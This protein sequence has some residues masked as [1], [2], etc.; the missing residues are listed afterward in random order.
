MCTRVELISLKF[1]APVYVA[2][3]SIE[4][5]LIALSLAE[6]GISTQTVSVR[7]LLDTDDGTERSQVELTD[8]GGHLERVEA[9]VGRA[10]QADPTRRPR[11]LGDPTDHPGQVAVLTRAAGPPAPSPRR[12]CF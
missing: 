4:R 3:G 9:R 1:C 12:R 6:R 10:E 8:R 11:L 7:T 5:S 2:E